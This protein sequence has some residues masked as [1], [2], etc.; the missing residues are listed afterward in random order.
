[1]VTQL[2]LDPTAF[3]NLGFVI[4]PISRARQGTSILRVRIQYETGHEN[5]VN[6]HQGNIQTVPL[7]IGQRARL[8]LDPL[9]RANIGLGPGKGTAIQVIGG[10]FGVVVDARGRPLRLP[11]EPDTRRN[12]LRK[13]QKAFSRRR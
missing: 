8:Y 3:L 13:W 10:P 11:K 4:A 2:L 1:L 5:V 9:H 6:V 7:P 12:L